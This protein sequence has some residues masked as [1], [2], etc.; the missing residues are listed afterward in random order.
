MN[1]EYDNLY[2]LLLIGDSG[3][4]KSSLLLRYSDDTYDSCYTSTIGVDFKIKTIILD[5]KVYKLQMWDTAG[6][7]RF[8]SIVSSYYKGAH[9]IILVIDLTNI[10]SFNNISMWLNQIT[11]N[12]YTKKSCSIL[13]VATK[14]DLID[15]RKITT[16]M[17]NSTGLNW[18]TTSSLNGKNVEKAFTTL[19]LDISINYTSDILENDKINI[20]DKTNKNDLRHINKKCC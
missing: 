16:K 13:L 17:L 5:D 6:Q 19:V 10:D 12:T 8:R 15:E 11:N 7:E 20:N 4:G 9:G 2:K 18:I 3:V 14:D 1:K